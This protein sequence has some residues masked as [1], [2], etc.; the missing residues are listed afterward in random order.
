MTSYDHVT[1]Q[2]TTHAL[3]EY[4]AE[5]F[6]RD[7]A[8][9]EKNLGI[10][11]ATTWSEYR[12]N[13]AAIALALKQMDLGEHP[14]AAIIGDNRP[15]W[16][17]AAIAVHASGGMSLGIYRD[18]LEEEL[19]YLLDYAKSPI[20]FC[21]DE[22]QVDK[23]LNLED[24]IPWVKHI[25]YDDTRGM[26]KYDDPRL[27]PLSDLLSKGKQIQAENP[28]AWQKLIKEGDPERT[29]VLCTT[30]GTTLQPKL[31][32]INHRALLLHSVCYLK[33]DPKD[34]NDEYVSSLPLPW[35]MEQMYGIGWNL[36]S[37]MKVNFVEEP[38]V[39]MHDLR[40]IG[41]TFALFAPRVWEQLAG[42][43][44]ARIMDSSWL[45]R[46][47][48]DFGMKLGLAAVEKGRHSLIAE[49]LLFRAL[50]DRL[51]LSH[52]RSAATGGAA[53][54]PDTFKFFLAMGVPMRQLY[55]Q[56]ELLGAYT[57]HRPDDV[58]FD[59][60]GIPF[61]G[62]ELSINDPD[63]DGLGEIVTRHPNMM[64]GYYKNPEATAENLDSEGRLLSGDAGYINKAGHLVVIDRVKDLATTSRR[65]RF[66]PQFIEN[67][68]K[69]SPYIAEAVI[70]GHERPFLA[71]MICIRFTV[72][73]KWAE[74]NRI[75]F[76]TYSD[77]C[78]KPEIQDMVQKEVALVNATLPEHQRIERFILLYKEL[79]AD[80][81]ELTRTKKVRRKT[82]AEKYADIIDCLYS[83]AEAVDI[84]TTIHFQDGT[85]Q[86]IVT[87]L[88]IIK[89]ETAQDK[90]A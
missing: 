16:L 19:L 86:R 51:G 33:N 25:F 64:Q 9:R 10:W 21:E 83:D 31:S 76:T 44:R 47:L 14:A 72:L 20:V 3:L 11:Q 70:L 48:Y 46:K 84:D 49:Y 53:L 78:T 23:F 80:D 62:V 28:D 38:E 5:H 12:D 77:L 85:S 89:M 7:I 68:L 69:F 79:D 2:L 41:P 54:G 29:A 37:R 36:V 67:K 34:G 73:S 17:F 13:V 26:R 50:R 65:H 71:A 6:P 43:V 45:K 24:R 42:D 55:G 8:L 40:E 27:R 63:Q 58:D 56:T 59:S 82:I 4:N 61:E 15:E 66:S 57:L 35:I 18:V 87:L 88:K 1:A 52:M 22:E 60:V 39:T 81:G 74:K 90:A 30:S 75:S 32:M